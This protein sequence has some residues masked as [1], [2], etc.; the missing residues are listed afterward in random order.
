MFDRASIFALQAA[1]LAFL[2]FGCAG[3]MHA[4]DTGP[5][6]VDPPLVEAARAQ[7]AQPFARL[8]IQ[9]S[10]CKKPM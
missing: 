7:K 4:A 3:F 5:Q 2:A 8:S 1:G 9:N 10:T 6:S